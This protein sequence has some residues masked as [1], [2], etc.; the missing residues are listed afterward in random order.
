MSSPLV[1][2]GLSHHTAPLDVRE[3]LAL[4][5]E[6]QTELLQAMAQAPAEA[7]LISTCNRVELYVV[8]PGTDLHE[9]TRTA[10]AGAAGDDLAPFLYSHHGEAAV[11]HLFRVAASLDSMV[12]GEP[13]ILGQVKDAFE[14]AQRLGAARGE[15]ARICAAAFGSAKRVRTE[16]ELGRAATSMASAAVEMARHVFDGLDGKTVLLVGAGEMAELSGKHLVAAGAAKVLVA[17]RT[18]ERAEAL[19]ASLG[20]QAVPFDRLEESLV[21]ADVVVC[22]T[23]SPK[24]VITREKVSRMLKPRKH[25]PLFLVDL[26]VPRDV[27]PEVQ[28]LDGVYAFDVDDIQK[29]VA[30]NQA[31]RTA[32]AGRAEVVVAEEV[33]RYIRQRAVREQVPVLAQL[34]ARAEQIRRAELERAIG[35]LPAPLT[36][37][38]ARVIEAM[39]SAIVNKMLHQPT[40]KLRAVEAGESELADAAAELFGLEGTA[41]KA[42]G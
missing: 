24:P 40:A 17:N 26:A 35:N 6:R 11:L 34:R 7:L 8:G 3:R 1:C 19:A 25:R 41:R 28:T 10:L 32:A 22:T 20:G 5:D 13:Q 37:D 12:L 23:A 31:A 36:A 2:V 4:P 29:V 16:T 27:E 14:Q 18:F 42:E 39:T 9:R 15:L 38:Q 30:E 21:L 33:A